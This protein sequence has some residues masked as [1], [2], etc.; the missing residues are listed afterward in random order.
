MVKR[1]ITEILE[2]IQNDETKVADYLNNAVVRCIFEYNYDP[3]KSFKLPKGTPPY[4]DA[5]EPLGMT[6]VNFLQ[7]CRTWPNLCRE[8]LTQLKRE[9]IFINMLEGVHPTEAV[10]LLAVKEG[11]LTKVYPFATMEFGVKHGFLAQ[12]APK[13]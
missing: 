3:A 5:P 9:N 8:D 6:P 4:R 12:T 10:I 11:T 2:E 7:T 13:E 1:M